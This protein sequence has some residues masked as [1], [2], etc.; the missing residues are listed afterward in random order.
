[1][2]TRIVAIV[3]ALATGAVLPP[4]ARGQAK[5]KVSVKITSPRNGATVTGPVTIKLR[6]T[7]VRIVPATVE[8]PGT[9]HHHLFVDHDLTWLNDTIPQGTPG[10][11]HLGRGQTQFVLD[12]LKPGP[13]R[14]IAVLA[15]WRHIPLNPLVAD[16]VTFTVK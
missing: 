9:A 8:R 12:S 1:M 16:T 14:V 6:A 10:I 11:I 2:R 5:A 7:G 3:L 15:D 4:V 13:H